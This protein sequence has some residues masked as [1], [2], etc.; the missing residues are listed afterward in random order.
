MLCFEYLSSSR[1]ISDPSVRFGEEAVQNI[2]ARAL[3]KWH[4]NDVFQELL[5]L[6]STHPLV[7]AVEALG[8]FRR[9]E[10]IPLL[11]QAL[12]DDVARRPAENALRALAEM[13]RSALVDA[14]RAPE[15]S[16]EAESRSSLLR[17]RSAV[18]ILSRR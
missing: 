7:G 11:V 2:A 4:S 1:R 17:R 18:R 16:A 13:A 3:R 14:A 12:G 8:T 5:Y 6:V 15:P 9:R 10:A